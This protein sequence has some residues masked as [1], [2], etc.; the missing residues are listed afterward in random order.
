MPSNSRLGL[1]LILTVAGSFGAFVV[2]GFQS[3]VGV[4]FAA[5]TAGLI[6]SLL[7][8]FV[9]FGRLFAREGGWRW[10]HAAMIIM[11]LHAILLFGEAAFRLVESVQRRSFDAAEAFLVNEYLPAWRSDAVFEHLH[12]PHPRFGL[13]LVPNTTTQFLRSTICINS[14]GTRGPEFSLEKAPG[15]LRVLCLGAST[16][17]GATV[18]A[19]D[20][21]YPEVLQELLRKQLHR[22]VTVINAGIAGARVQ[23]TAN[24]L[25]GELLRFDPDVAVVYHGFSD[26]PS[27]ISGE[28]RFHP[29]GSLLVQQAMFLYAKQR[30]SRRHDWRAYH[31]NYR[32]GLDRIANLCADNDVK[33]FLCTFA[34]AYDRTTPRSHVEFYQ[35]IMPLY[36]SKGGLAALEGIETNNQIVRGV[37]KKWELAV[38]DMAAV[39]GG[40][41]EHF[42]DFCHFRQSGRDVFAARVAHA[43]TDWLDNRHETQQGSVPQPQP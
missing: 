16:T 3:R 2:C 42:V 28:R 9:L 24:R 32:D 14:H 33:L 25:E 18:E 23:F 29:K 10:L 43:L 11:S 1:I 6:G 35:R 39:L 30:G 31:E 8:F 26:M 38:I 12:E 17:W 21:P 13:T 15:E 41:Q 7:V 4:F 19:D 5:G 37:A 34:L 36:G 40:R 27:G 20:R 22:S